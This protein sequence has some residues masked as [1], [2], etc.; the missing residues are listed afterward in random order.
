MLFMGGIVLLNIPSVTLSCFPHMYVV[1]VSRII[2]YFSFKSQSI[3][4]WLFILKMLTHTLAG[5]AQWIES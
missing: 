2:V 3:A 4:G 1:L 5:V